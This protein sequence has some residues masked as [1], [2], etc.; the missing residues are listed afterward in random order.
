MYQNAFWSVN[1]LDPHRAL[2]FDT[3]HFDDSGVNGGHLWPTLKARLEERGRDSEST[4]EA[5]YVL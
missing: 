1:N 4:V 5:Q 2:S 3:L